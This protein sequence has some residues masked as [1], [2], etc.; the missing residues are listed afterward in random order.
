MAV[1]SRP[2]RQWRARQSWSWSGSARRRR[3]W[4]WLDQAIAKHELPLAPCGYPLVAPLLA[5]APGLYVTGGLAE[6]ELGPVA[7][8]IS[9]T[10]HAG[11]RLAAVSRH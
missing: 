2:W 10:R 3:R 9:G 4:P 8:N 1:M 6:L 7:R 11:E 5:W